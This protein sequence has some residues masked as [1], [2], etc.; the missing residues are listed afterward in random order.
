MIRIPRAHLNVEVQTH[1]GMAGKNNEDRYAVASFYANQ[2]D[3]TPIL[4]AVLADGIG[5]H[6]GGEVAAELAV[7]HIMQSVAR[8]DGK[9]SRRVIEQAVNEASEAIAAHA[10]ANE[11]LKG[12]GATCAIAWIIG[13]KLHTAYVGDSR[14]YL[15]RGGR[16]QQLTIDHTWVQEAID[17]GIL[18]PELA[19]QHPNVHVIRRY[20]GSPVPPD[21]D[22]R[23]NLFDGEGAHH[24]ENNQGT[25]L[26]PNDVL[27]LCSD[28]LTD[29]VWNDEILE[30]V[31]TK[32]NLK[33]AA[34]ALIDLANQ[35]GGHDN[36]TVILIGVP[37]DFRV[38]P[39]KKTDWMLWMIGAL[40]IL[41]LLLILAA[42]FLTF[43][44]LRRTISVTPTPLFS[45][46]P[47]VTVT[48]PPLPTSTPIPT[49]TPAPDVI[50]PPAPTYTPWPTNTISP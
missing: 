6:R 18:T 41:F 26:Q 37:S 30:I 27:L 44:L 14:I 36:I 23:L 50:L 45:P 13:D 24:A 17:K 7:N 4:F 38:K 2:Q 25:A 34:R 32:S 33:E 21:P 11:D 3:K 39:K 20:L 15:I 1:P 40:T 22:F 42:S 8:S 29:L 49:Q 43:S 48:S 10:A 47:L 35:R 28:G 12:M 9:F 46:T 16:I 5:G 31:R 19:R